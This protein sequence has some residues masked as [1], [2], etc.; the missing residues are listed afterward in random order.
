MASI[1][2]K[3]RP[4]AVADHEG[5][6]YYQIIHERKVR[7]LFTC[8][9]VFPHEWDDKRSMVTTI[10][11]SERKPHIL[12]I[13]ER[14]RWAMERLTKINRKFDKDGLSYTVDDVVEE[15][16]R[17][18]SDYTLFNYMESAIIKLKQ[19]GKVRTAETYIVTLNS[20]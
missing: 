12:S 8:Y 10:Q 5:T 7:Q 16:N 11:N 19:N 13:R 15:F 14:I 17:Y 2:V 20:F 9:K 3:F 18:A 6:I 1:K 4:S